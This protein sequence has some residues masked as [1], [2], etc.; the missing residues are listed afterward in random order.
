MLKCH[1]NKDVITEILIYRLKMRSGVNIKLNP[2]ITL[3]SSIT[4]C[5]DESLFRFCNLHTEVLFKF[6]ISYSFSA[7]LW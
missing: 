1:K 3:Y 5:D 6:C 7:L 4:I 2:G